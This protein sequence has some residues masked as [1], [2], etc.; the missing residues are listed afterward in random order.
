MP[1]REYLVHQKRSNM[2]TS[3]NSLKTKCKYDCP[4]NEIY[5]IT[6][7]AVKMG[8]LQKEMNERQDEHFFLIYLV[9]WLSKVKEAFTREAKKAEQSKKVVHL[10]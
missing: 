5:F 8:S 9:S 7:S 3:G 4:F 1:L 6:L 2:S 10:F